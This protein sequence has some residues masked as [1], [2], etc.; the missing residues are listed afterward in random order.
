[1]VYLV[2]EFFIF[3]ERLLVPW[4]WMGGSPGV[5]LGV[6]CLSHGCGLLFFDLWL[7]LPELWAWY[8]VVA[9]WHCIWGLWFLVF[10][11]W[12]LCIGCCLP[13]LLGGAKAFAVYSLVALLWWGM[14]CWHG[15]YDGSCF[16]MLPFC[17][18]CLPLV[19]FLGVLA[20]CIVVCLLSFITLLEIN[21]YLSKKKKKF[22]L[23]EECPLEPPTNASRTV[24][25]R[26]DSWIHSNN[27][28]R[29]YMLASM[30]D[31]LRKKHEDTETA[32]EIWESLQAMFGQQ[33]DQCRHEATRSYMNAK[34][35]K[36][37]SAKEHVLN[38]INRMHETEIHGATIDERTQVSIILE[39]LTPT[40]S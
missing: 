1:M 17:R 10:V 25:E 31:V 36:G 7:P 22:V 2:V 38:M 23:T 37:V 20:S 8:L 14:S 28:A 5:P 12:P 33:S 40:F 34:M 4:L 9:C 39:S 35:K 13:L 16:E 21:S 27:K 30:N 15:V 18:G 6:W 29:C 26:Y 24:R 3:I 32:Y 19:V 11:L